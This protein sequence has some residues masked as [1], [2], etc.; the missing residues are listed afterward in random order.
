MIAAYLG[1]TVG[2]SLIISPITTERIDVA[3]MIQN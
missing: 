2:N 1:N 3:A